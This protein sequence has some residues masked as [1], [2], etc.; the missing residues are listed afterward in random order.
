[1]GGQLSALEEEFGVVLG[2][3]VGAQ[4]SQELVR[5]VSPSTLNSAALLLHSLVRLRSVCEF[6]HH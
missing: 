1:M 4:S 3:C 6:A 2:V 5:M